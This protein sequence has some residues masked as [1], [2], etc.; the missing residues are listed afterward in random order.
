MSYSTRLKAFF[1]GCVV[2]FTL[3]ARLLIALPLVIL[4]PMGGLAGIANELSIVVALLAAYRLTERLKS[5]HAKRTVIRLM[6][7]GW[8]KWLAELEARKSL[9]A[10]SAESLLKNVA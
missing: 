6:E 9:F 1:L 4:G 5:Y 7:T 8:V 3:M 2:G 10:N